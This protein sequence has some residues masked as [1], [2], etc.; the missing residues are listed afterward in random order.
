MTIEEAIIICNQS[1]KSGEG[2]DLLYFMDKKEDEIAYNIIK[3]IIKK[4]G[5]A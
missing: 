4:D 2:I 5:K 1:L 3:N